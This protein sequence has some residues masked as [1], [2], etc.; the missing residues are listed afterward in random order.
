LAAIFQPALA[1]EC[2][3]SGDALSLSSEFSSVASVASFYATIAL[4]ES[5]EIF[6]EEVLLGLDK[7]QGEILIANSY[8]SA[9]PA[10][11]SACS[12]SVIASQFETSIVSPIVD[13]LEQ[14][15][16]KAGQVTAAGSQ[17]AMSNQLV[18]LQQAFNTME[19]IAFSQLSCFAISSMDA[20]IN[21]INSA[22]SAALSVYSA[23]YTPAP[24]PPAS[25]SRE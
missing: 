9:L 19:G 12:Q 23:T 1:Q 4:S 6:S 2:S 5:F 17:F 3:L 7:I 10:G 8:A 24:T 15:S 14:L 13:I 25:C 21:S 16:I 18:L 22:F 20:G 11:A